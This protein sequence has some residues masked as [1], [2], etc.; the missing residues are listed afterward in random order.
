MVKSLLIRFE[1]VDK[2]Q[3]LCVI[4][5]EPPSTFERQLRGTA[6]PKLLDYLRDGLS[7]VCPIPKIY[8]CCPHIAISVVA[9]VKQTCFRFMCQRT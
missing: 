5:E 2:H 4:S 1:A 9:L 7:S 8:L 6:A 3:L